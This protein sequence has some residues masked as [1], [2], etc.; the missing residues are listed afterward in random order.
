MGTFAS[1]GKKTSVSSAHTLSDVTR[2]KLESNFARVC[3]LIIDEISFV[4]CDM[5]VE[6]EH[7]LRIAKRSTR[8]FGG[9]HIICIGDHYQLPPVGG[10][11]LVTP[12][13]E[14]SAIDYPSQ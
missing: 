4:S 5:L 2:A 11:A 10:T 8:P 9:L 3:F 13:A 1:S 14:E 12:S 6:V 7:R